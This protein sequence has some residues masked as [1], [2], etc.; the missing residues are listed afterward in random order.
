MNLPLRSSGASARFPLLVAASVLVPT[1][2]GALVIYFMLASTLRA[3]VERLA[4]VRDAVVSE[5]LGPDLAAQA[6]NVAAQLDTFLLE[7]IHEAKA[8]ASSEVVVNSA[9][10]AHQRHVELGF[11]DAEADDLEERF[12]ISKS[13]GA[14]PEADAY[15]RQQ[16]A[17]SSN[18]AEAF[19]TDRLGYNVAL[20]NPTSDFIQS[21]E[22]WWLAAWS[23]EIAVGT[24]KYDDS[25]GVWSLEFAIRIDDPADRTALGVL[26]TVLSISPVQR[27]ADRSADSLPGSRVVVATGEGLLLAETVSRH[28]RERIMREPANVRVHGTPGEQS[29]FGA[30][31]SAFSVSDGF[32]TAHA[33]TA[34]ADRY[35]SVVPRFRGFDWII[36]LQRPL[37]SVLAP[38]ADLPATAVALSDAT[39]TLVVSLASVVVLVVLVAFIVPAA[40]FRRWAHDVEAMTAFVRGVIEGETVRRPVSPRVRELADLEAS[41]YQ[42]YRALVAALRR[43]R[44]QSQPPAGT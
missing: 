42:L 8:W 19:F 31:R 10:D 40:V 23:H 44:A 21:D 1:L 27:I 28:A 38:I 14:F 29:A 26:K 36:I 13:L 5:R 34:G 35:T 41:V 43:M 32:L 16:V 4:R 6:R 20:T 30:E 2:L 24:V 11:A 7:R 12:R 37:D 25:A 39:F 3:S 9:R 22:G 17:V 33:R 18:F 15:L